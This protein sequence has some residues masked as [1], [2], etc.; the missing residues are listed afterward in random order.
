MD[1][2]SWV[3][4]RQTSRSRPLSRY[5]PV[6]D[7]SG[8]SGVQSEITLQRLLQLLEQHVERER[9]QQPGRYREPEQQIQRL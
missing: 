2:K 5:V 9:W 4:L 6:R 8:H 1:D 7:V 3:A